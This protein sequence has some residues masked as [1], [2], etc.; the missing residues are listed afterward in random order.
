[1]NTQKPGAAPQNPLAVA[2]KQPTRFT[3][4][5]PQG[6][7]GNVRQAVVLCRDASTSM[8][9]SKAQEASQAVRELVEQLA[10]EMNK[11]AFDVA[12]IDFHDEV[13]VPH[14]LGRAGALLSALQPIATGGSGTDISGPLAQAEA[15]L[16]APMPGEG[17]Y[18]R[19]V[20]LLFTDGGH[21]TG[22]DPR[23]IAA[24]LRSFAD[25]VTVAFGADADEALLTELATTPSH[26]YRCTNG[27]QLRAFLVAV[28]T[29][30]ITTRAQ[31]QNATRALS[32][33][34]TK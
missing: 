31:G 13:Q 20:I 30:V 22:A 19:P 12:V 5:R 34:R 17:R 6:L 8:Q 4:N 23:P 7:G 28:A 27:S 2:A 18:V 33:V 14:P 15:L 21:N 10:L 1:M 32:Q 16:K 24:R 25:L 3:V 26:F 29:T 9:G 11:D